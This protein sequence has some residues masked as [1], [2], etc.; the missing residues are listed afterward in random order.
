MKLLEIHAHSHLPKFSRNRMTS[1]GMDELYEVIS[2]L[3]LKSVT[4]KININ[5]KKHP[6]FNRTMVHMVERN[7]QCFYE[8]LAGISKK[9][10]TTLA[11]RSG[12]LKF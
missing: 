1:K 4:H 2:K 3:D 9:K 10:G 6:L 12:Y 8:H 7:F 11:L 5:K